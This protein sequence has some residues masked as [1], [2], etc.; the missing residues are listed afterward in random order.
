[1]V[2]RQDLLQDMLRLLERFFGQEPLSLDLD[3]QGLGDVRYYQV[4]Q[5]TNAEDDVLRRN[6]G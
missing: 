4:D 3:V 1:M 2:V 6:G 5:A